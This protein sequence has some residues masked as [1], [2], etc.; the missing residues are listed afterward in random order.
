MLGKPLLNV[1]A[2][3]C[4]AVLAEASED[5]G[6][7]WPATVSPVRGHDEQNISAA[8]SESTPRTARNDGDSPARFWGWLVSPSRDFAERTGGRRP[9]SA[10]S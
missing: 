6:I 1:G 5:P 2:R 3:V 10:G 9:A 7:V 4:S 8:A